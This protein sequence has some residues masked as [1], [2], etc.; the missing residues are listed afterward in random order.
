M[1]AALVTSVSQA[2]DRM[3]ALGDQSLFWDETFA[4][5]SRQLLARL[6]QG[7][8]HARISRRLEHCAR[9]GV[10]DRRNGSYSRHLVTAPGDVTVRV[11]QAVFIVPGC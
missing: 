5:E 10:S 3:K 8:M 7:R 1:G 9:D 4:Q 6:I 11:P 2:M